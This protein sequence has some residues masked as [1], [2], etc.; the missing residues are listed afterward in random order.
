MFC[1]EESLVLQTSKASYLAYS[2]NFNDSFICLSSSS[3]LIVDVVGGGGCGRV[4]VVVVV[5]G[6]VAT[7]ALNTPCMLSETEDFKE[8][9]RL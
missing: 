4:V 6:D 2:R 7:V 3:C 1:K 5:D 9:L 8:F